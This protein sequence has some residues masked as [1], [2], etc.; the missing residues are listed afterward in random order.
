MIMYLTF[1]QTLILLTLANKDIINVAYLLRNPLCTTLPC[2]QSV[3]GRE[4]KLYLFHVYSEGAK[5]IPRGIVCSLGQ[6]LFGLK[7]NRREDD[8]IH[9]KILTT[10]LS[11]IASGWETCILTDLHCNVLRMQVIKFYI[12][13]IHCI[14]NNPATGRASMSTFYTYKPLKYHLCCCQKQYETI[15]CR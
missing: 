12:Q 4:R 3:D 8:E 1:Q 5:E 10:D 11:D 15:R 2:Q 9:R 6:R 7:T 13:C 14:V